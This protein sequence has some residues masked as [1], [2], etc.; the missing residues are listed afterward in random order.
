MIYFGREFCTAKDHT[1]SIPSCFITYT[2]FKV[3]FWKQPAK[4]PVCSFIA[5]SDKP[6]PPLDELNETLIRAQFAAAKRVKGIVYYQD[7]TDQLK[8]ES[9]LILGTPS[10]I[11]PMK[12]K[13]KNIELTH[14]GAITSLSM[15]MGAES[16]EDS[17]IM[18]RHRRSVP[19]SNDKLIDTTAVI[20]DNKN[21]SNRKKTTLQTYTVAT[22]R[23]VRSRRLGSKGAKSVVVRQNRQRRS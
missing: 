1:V 8:T 2:L 4:C 21:A 3:L 23:S 12:I 18:K 10:P 13:R 5:P 17:I 11:V 6:L 16:K 9:H 20:D 15:A 22:S 7:R 14:A 19:K